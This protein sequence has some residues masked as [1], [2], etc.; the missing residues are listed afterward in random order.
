M[1]LSRCVRDPHAPPRGPQ[2]SFEMNFGYSEGGERKNALVCAAA[3]S[4]P[5]VSITISTHVP[6]QYLPS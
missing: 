1:M 4:R 2:R 6:Q 5:W 3:R